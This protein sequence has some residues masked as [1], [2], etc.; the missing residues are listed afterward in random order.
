MATV[1]RT[2]SDEELTALSQGL[3]GAEPQEIVRW[4][5]ETFFPDITLACSFGGVSGMALLDIALKINPQTSV[6][7]LDTDFL[8]PE[9]YALRDQAAKRYGFQPIGFKSDLTPEQQA[10][11]HGEALW[12]RDP[13]L[14]CELRKVKPNARALAGHRAWIAGLRRDQ[15]D[16][17]KEVAIV[18]WDSKFNLLK[19]NPLANWNEAQ[20]WTYIMKNNVLY[21]PLHDQGYPSI[22]C[23]Y[24]TKA[25]KPGDDPRAGRWVGFDKVE[26]GIHVDP[27][28]GVVT[29]VPL[30][31]ADKA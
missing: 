21:N 12:S 15:G 30:D 3:E 8:F 16:T 28:T 20:V 14:C 27:V 31:A 11:E 25:V 13:D 6:F 19:V 24:C 23:T 17:R 22:G 2:H 5:L 1:Q 18:A 29:Q 9:V 4:A 10:R 7:Y 26:C